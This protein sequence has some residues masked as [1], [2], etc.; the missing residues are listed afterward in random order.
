MINLDALLDEYEIK[1]QILDIPLPSGDVLKFSVPGS[2]G[3]FKA[4]E[5]K[6]ISQWKQLDK[7][8]PQE[9][10]AHVYG[11]LFPQNADDFIAALT[12]SNFSH[13]PK[14]NMRDAL[15]MTRCPSLVVYILNS[16]EAGQ[17]TVHARWIFAQ[18]EALG[19]DSPQ[20]TDTD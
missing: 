13:E 8:S 2:Y 1:D 12:I 20:T 3:E 17:K 7:L 5:K 10:Q 14:F 6:A 15:K 9:K 19:E 4:F 16:L 11:D 18:A